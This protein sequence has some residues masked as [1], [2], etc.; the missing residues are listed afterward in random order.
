M[1]L[2]EFIKNTLVCIKN[3]VRNAN[4]EFGESP[5]FCIYGSTK[6]GNIYFDIAVTVSEQKGETGGGS[7]KI[8]VV[9][10][11]GKISSENHQ[12]QTS[13]IKFSITPNI[14]IS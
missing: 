11:G 12:E 2:D 4:K 9:D 13:R 14:D 5:Y 10:V 7:I 8:A 1:E 3:G 6:D